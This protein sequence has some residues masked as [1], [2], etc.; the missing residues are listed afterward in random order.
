MCK[1]V[2]GEKLSFCTSQ[3][4]WQPKVARC[5]VNVATVIVL[6]VFLSMCKRENKPLF[7]SGSVLNTQMFLMVFAEKCTHLVF[8]TTSVDVD[9]PLTTAGQDFLSL[10]H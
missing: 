1:Y 4:I 5:H 6:L 7:Y 10:L 3:Q 8:P 2:G 9:V